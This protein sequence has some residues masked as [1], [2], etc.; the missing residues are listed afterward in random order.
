MYTW[1]H[2][3]EAKRA[4]HFPYPVLGLVIMRR[5]SAPDHVY[6]YENTEVCLRLEDRAEEAEDIIDGSRRRTPFPHAVFKYPG[7]VHRYRTE[8][9]DAFSFF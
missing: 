4:A 1:I 3:N 2:L 8:G 9:R 5:I 6:T 7:S